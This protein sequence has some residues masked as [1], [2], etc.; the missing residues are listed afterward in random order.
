MKKTLIALAA[1][2]AFAGAAHANDIYVGVNFPSVGTIGYAHNV[3]DNWALRA[4]YSAGMNISGTGNR[5][6]VEMTGTFSS[7]VAGAY[8]DWFPFDGSGFRLTAGMT[9]N[10]TRLD[11]A[12]KGTGYATI[13]GKSVNMAGQYYN[14]RVAMPAT[15]PYLGIGYGHQ[16]AEKGLGFYADFGAMIGQFTVESQTSLVQA[17]LVSQSDID[18]QNQSIKDG[19]N[20]L[21][22]IPVLAMGAVY[23]F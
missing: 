12:A 13:N 7:R 1:A 3:G 11:L 21:G 5:Q 8:A 22:F 15:T 10:D 16:K 19:A 17:G 4:D 18:A 23:R 6:G 14:V 2:A 20:G 9:A